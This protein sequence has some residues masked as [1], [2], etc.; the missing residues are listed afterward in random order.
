MGAASFIPDY[1][2]YISR[3]RVPHQ[4]TDLESYDVCGNGSL[5]SANK[6]MIALPVGV[7]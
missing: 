5:A 7:L 6:S 1:E 4:F 3:S 2:L